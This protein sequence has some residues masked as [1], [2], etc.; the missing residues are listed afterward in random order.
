MKNY[1]IEGNAREKAVLTVV[2]VAIVLS[3]L[4]YSP[5]NLLVEGLIAAVPSLS[6]LQQIGLLGAIEPLAIYGI[7][8][9]VYGKHLW[10]LSVFRKLHHVPD[11]NGQWKGTFQSSFPDRDGQRTVK[12]VTMT[13]NQTFTSINI[14]CVFPG[15][16]E[17]YAEVAGILDCDEE[18]GGCT[19]EF[20]YKNSATDNSQAFDPNRD[21]SHLGL[22]VLRITGEQ[23]T[24][25]YV[26]LRNESTRGFME[27]T[28]V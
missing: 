26:T 10:R 15:S 14:R 24:G 19:L 18:N 13:I 11:L 20:S 1:S 27:L 3:A 17:S 2:L 12:D 22:N 9:A 16:S 5:T 8:W 4:L 23:A 7:L 28:R 21:N 6:W 25:S